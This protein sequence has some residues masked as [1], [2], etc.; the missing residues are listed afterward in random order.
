MGRRGSV[1]DYIL[2]S[3]LGLVHQ[4]R[5]GF[6]RAGSRSRGVG[7]KRVTSYNNIV[8]FSRNSV[9]FHVYQLIKVLDYYIKL[10]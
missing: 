8:L 10:I 3:E 1:V 5:T 9:I 7:R 6:L 4:R 2:V